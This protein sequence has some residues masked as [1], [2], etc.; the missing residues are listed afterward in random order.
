MNRG[1]EKSHAGQVPTGEEAGMSIAQRSQPSLAGR[2]AVVTGASGSI[3]GAICRV[4][5]RKGAAVVASG[6]NVAALEHVATEIRTAGG[7]AVVVVADVTDPT[8][9]TRLRTEA[10]ARLGS[11]D[12]LAV[13]A[14]GGGEPVPLADLT[15]E[16]WRATVDLNLTSA[17]LTL[18]T[19]LPGMAQRGRGAAVTMASLAGEH[20]MPQAKIAA[21]PA[22]AAAKAGLLMLTRQAAREYAPHGVRVNC[23]SPGSVE[24]GR[25]R[26]MPT[27]MR[28]ALE[29]SHP[30]GRI[31]A[32][33]DVAEATAYLLGDA[34]SWI[35]GA[36]LDVNGG[37]A[38][39]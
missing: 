30:L 3:G 10:E 24:N 8:A 25:I 14:G 23:I 28:R 21:S 20:V 36:T 34:A 18:A 39:L 1:E 17:F 4:L 19:F 38:M 37:F 6:R 27:E 29:A 12:L 11:V 33:E 31:G 15:L 7:Q 22:Y 26:G 2:V 9:V 16:R 5:A 32:P 35:T 13:V